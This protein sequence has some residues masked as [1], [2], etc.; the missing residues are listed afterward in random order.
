M[1]RVI[2][3][4][5]SKVIVTSKSH[6]TTISI[7]TIATMEPS[8]L[9]RNT[10][11]GVYDLDSVK[12]VFEDCFLAHVSY[13]D[14]GLPACLPMIALVREENE[15]DIA[16][17]SEGQS[18][19]ESPREPAKTAVYLHGHP[20]ARLMELVRKAN[21]SN[22]GE[23]DTRAIDQVKVCITATKGMSAPF[24]PGAYTSG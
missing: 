6:F 22:D 15:E 19:T 14:D 1:F 24:H 13:V 18:R 7:R 23:T 21:R 3:Q 5:P 17:S 11:K 10:N 9:R 4:H 16:I 2:Q 12:S 8:Y 20:S